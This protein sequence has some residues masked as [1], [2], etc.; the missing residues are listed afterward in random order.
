MKILVAAK[1]VPDPNATIKVRPDG[2]GIVTDNVK[3]VVNPFCEIA[4]EE[5]LRI[6]EKHGRRRGRAGQRR[7]Q[8]RAGA[9]AHRP[10]DGRRPRHP[11]AQR[12]RGRAGASSRAC[13][14]EAHR[15]PSSPTS[16]SWASRRS[17]TTRT[18]SARWSPRCSAGARPPF[19][20][21]VEACRRQEVR[22][23]DARG[24]R[25]PRGRRDPAARRWSPPICA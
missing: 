3:Y 23:G 2:T 15:R 4:I 22:G 10:G 8:G 24:R 12:A 19:A 13:S 9:A 25:R 20:S 6:K 11:G 21:A 14:Q 1:R 17:T 7:R 16:S 5:A 18:S